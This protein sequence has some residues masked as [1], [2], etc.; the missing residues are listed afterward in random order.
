MI[1]NLTIDNISSHS[2]SQSFDRIAHELINYWTLQVNDVQFQFTEIKFYYF[3]STNHPDTFTHPHKLEEGMW[4][5]H[6][7]GLDITFQSYTGSDGGILIRGIKE[8]NVTKNSFKYINGPKKVLERIFQLFGSV[9]ELNKKLGL[10]Y[11]PDNIHSKI[12]KTFRKGL[13]KSGHQDFLHSPY[14]Y[15]IDLENWNR[16]YLSESMKFLIKEKSIKLS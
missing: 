14:R 5:F 13:R 8:F 16:N 3:H 12:Y 7:Q 10:V 1:L 11:K 4:R 15:Y 2:I 9:T 6:L